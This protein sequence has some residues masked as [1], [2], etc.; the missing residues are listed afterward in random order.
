MIKDIILGW[1]E[2]FGKKYFVVGY[3]LEAPQNKFQKLFWGVTLVILP[4]VA[5]MKNPRMIWD[6]IW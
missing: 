6:G 3:V 1:L 2:C 4:R 5:R